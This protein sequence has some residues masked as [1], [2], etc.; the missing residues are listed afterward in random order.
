MLNAPILKI[1]PFFS[2][3]SRRKSV[4]PFYT[5]KTKCFMKM[6]CGWNSF[7]VLFK[8]VPDICNK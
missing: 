3:S 1:C 6:F 5:C 8:D 7:Q 2:S 4:L